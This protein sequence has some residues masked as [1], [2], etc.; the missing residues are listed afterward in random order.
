M[1]TMYFVVISRM[2]SKTFSLDPSRSLRSMALGCATWNLE[3]ANQSRHCYAVV[4]LLFRK[5]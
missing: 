5:S 1:K 3:R 4:K 2:G